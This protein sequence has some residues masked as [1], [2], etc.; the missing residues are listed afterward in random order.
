METQEINIPEISNQVLQ[1]RIDKIKWVQPC[2]SG[3][4][5]KPYKTE[6]TDSKWFD[7]FETISFCN[8]RTQAFNFDEN[9]VIETKQNLEI[10]SKIEI[11]V[12]IGGYYGL[13]KVTMAEVMS[14]IP[15]ECLEETI[16]FSF[17]PE[18]SVKI[19][20]EDYQLLPLILYKEGNQKKLEELLKFEGLI[21][22]IDQ[23]K[24][25]KFLKAG[26]KPIIIYDGEKPI[27]IEP[28]KINSPFM[29]F[30]IQM[31]ISGSNL[32]KTNKETPIIVPYKIGKE[33]SIYQEFN[34]DADIYEPTYSYTV[35]QIPEYLVTENTIGF[36]YKRIDYFRT[37]KG[38]LHKIDYC[39]IEKEL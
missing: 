3:I 18:K 12:K 39:I 36:Q 6:E 13:L 28:E 27:S 22:E 9:S 14:Q 25:S 17:D 19:L 1:E 8:P 30:G 33:F 32:W 29:T 2:M 23:F 31:R 7:L 15:K 24:T 38:I 10:L 11:F 26:I 34:G 5:Q 35:S 4:D 16:A 37:D 21:K 20:N